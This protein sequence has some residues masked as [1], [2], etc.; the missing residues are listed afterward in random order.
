MTLIL[1]WPLVLTPNLSYGL[2][3]SSTQRQYSDISHISYMLCDIYLTYVSKSFWIN[4]FFFLILVSQNFFLIPFY[5][6]L[7]GLFNLTGFTNTK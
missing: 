7:Y 4:S 1:K 6:P 2:L 5:F 3:A